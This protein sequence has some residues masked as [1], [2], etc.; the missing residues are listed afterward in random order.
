MAL[1]K[2]LASSTGTNQITTSTKKVQIR[3]AVIMS[4]TV[5]EFNISQIPISILVVT[6]IYQ[7]M[8][9]IVTIPHEFET[10][11]LS[12]IFTDS[13]I[14]PLWTAFISKKPNINRIFA[15]NTNNSKIRH[16]RQ[17]SLTTLSRGF[18]E[19]SKM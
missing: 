2:Q 6:V 9:G 7:T 4:L 14:N 10:I 8:T 15:N 18:A 11:A 5:L 17:S 12:F 19:S 1:E 16:G 13:I 3:L